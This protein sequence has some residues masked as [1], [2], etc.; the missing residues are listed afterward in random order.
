M[1]IRGLNTNGA[2]IGWYVSRAQQLLAIGRP[3]AQVAYFHPTDSM[4]MGDQE[5][6]DVTDLNSGD[7]VAGTSNRFRSH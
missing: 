6:D 3:A 2:S 1:N 7:P 5:S 4:W